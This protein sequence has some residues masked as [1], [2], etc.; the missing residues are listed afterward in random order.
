MEPG[1]DGFPGRTV[2]RDTGYALYDLESDI[3]ERTNLVELRPGVVSDLMALA[4]QAR[5]DL[6]DGDRPGPGVRARLP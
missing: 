5:A 2:R 1:R 4:G 3:G 6:G